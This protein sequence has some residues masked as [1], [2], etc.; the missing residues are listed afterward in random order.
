MTIALCLA[1]ILGLLGLAFARENDLPRV[2][3]GGS[4]LEGA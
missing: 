1:L 3:L 4:Q 2:C